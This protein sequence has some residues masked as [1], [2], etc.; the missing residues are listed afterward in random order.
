[1]DCSYNLDNK[2]AIES[3]WNEFTLFFL[4]LNIANTNVEN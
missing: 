1:M 4:G 2:F 3:I